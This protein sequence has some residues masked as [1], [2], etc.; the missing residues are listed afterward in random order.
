MLKRKRAIK[1]AVGISLAAIATAISAE[2]HLLSY[3]DKNHLRENATV[4]GVVMSAKYL[5]SKRHSPTLLDLDR[6]YPNQPFTIVIWGDDRA[7]FGTPEVGYKGKRV[8]VSGTLT[9]FRGT[10]EIVA[11]DPA[12]ITTE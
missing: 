12:Q 7:K 4:C 2:P 6:A 11:K 5:E 1:L 10:P 8:C 3:Q 9:E